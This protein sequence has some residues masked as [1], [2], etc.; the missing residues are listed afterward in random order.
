MSRVD[1]L[2]R[3]LEA[4]A[5]EAADG[6]KIVL[7]ERRKRDGPPQ[8]FTLLSDEPEVVAVR[9]DKFSHSSMLEDGWKRCD[10]ALFVGRKDSSVS[11]VLLIELKEDKAKDEESSE[12]LRQSVPILDYLEAAARVGASP[13][14]DPAKAV[15]REVHYVVLY[16]R[17]GP[18]VD[19]Q[20]THAA[21]VVATG[22]K[23]YRGMNIRWRIGRHA[24]LSDLLSDAGGGV[25]SSP[26]GNSAG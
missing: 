9:M 26:A 21:S 25:R 8:S 19:K 12:Q 24:D 4:R 18:L 6:R 15:P 23:W 13:D 20:A 16:E 10:Y 22:R 11:D 3:I 2:R 7:K 17:D 1:A 14:E 5:L